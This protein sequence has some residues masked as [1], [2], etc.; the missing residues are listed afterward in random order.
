MSQ[1]R[2]SRQLRLF[3][4][5][6]KRIALAISFV[7]SIV[8]CIPA[9]AQMQLVPGIS[10]YAGNGTAG[11]SGDGGAATSAQLNQTQGVAT[12]S[13][14]NLYIAD[15]QNNRVRKVDAATGVMTT[16]AGTGTA[17]YS[18][19]GAAAT[20][21]MLKGPTGV[22]VDS[23]GNVYIADQA[24]N[25][26]RR[27]DA[28]TG[29]ITTIAGNGTT[30][31]SGDGGP[32]T[33]AAMFSPTDLI[34][35]SA[36]DLYIS[37][38]GNHRIRKVAAGTGVIT[39][40]AGNGTPGYSGDGGAATS[41][42]LYYP[43]GMVVDSAGNLYIADTFN[44]RVRKVAAGTGVITTYAGTGTAGFAGD[45][46]AAASA[47]FN[48]P[49]R[50]TLDKAGNMFIADQGNNRVREIFLGTGIITTVAGDGTAGF[51][52]DGGPGTAAAFHTPLG[53]AID[54]A[55]SLYTSDS[56]NNRIR[57]LAITANNFPSTKIG[58]TSVVQEILLQTTAAETITSITIPQ[59]Q[60]GKQ[61][62]SIGTIT[63]CTIGA[64]N[65]A[66]TVCTIPVTFTP[67]YPGQRWV[68]LQ[69][70]TSTGNINFGLTG[71]GQGPLAAL[72]P[73]IITTVVGNGTAGYA[74]DSGP[75]TTAELNSPVGVAFDSA[76]N[77]YIGDNS[78]SRVR[79]VNAAT[80]IITTVVGNGT[81]GYSG[82]G[83]PA[84]SAELN[85]PEVVALDS[86]GNLYIAEYYNN[87]I[88]K[89]AAATGIIT[90]V[91]GNGTQNYSGDGG[92]ATSA[93][94]W[95]PTGVAVDSA[96]NLY[97]ADFGNHRIR[98]VAATGIITTV[99]GNGTLGYSGD[100]GPATSAELADPTHV[101]LDSVG[102]L[103]IADPGNNR[104][105]KVTVAT[106]IITTIAGNGTAGYSGDGGPATSAAL[107]NPEYLTLD[108]AD[109][110]YIGDYLNN[111]VRKLNAA[112]GIIT[113]IAGNGT[114]AYA[115]DAGAATSA[116]LHY[117]SAIAFDNVGN[118]YVSDLGNNRTRKLDL[119]QSV[120][121]Y[122]TPT[123][124]GTSD[125]TDNPQTA[126]V[127]NIG[128][129]DLTIPPPSSG[130]NPNVGSSFGFDSAST[131]PEL[132]A[133]SNPQTL[134]AGANCTI[135]IEFDPVQAGALTGSAVLTDT[136]LNAAAVTQTIHLIATGVAAN[137]TTTLASSVNPSAYQQSVT[138]TATVVPT[139]GAALPTGT[140][141][142][143]V[144]GAAAGGPVPLNGSGVATLTSTT[145]AVGTHSI[146]A[147]Y[148]PDSTSFTASSATALS[149]V[150][151]KATLGQNGLANITLTSSPNPSNV[152]QSVTFTAT[153]PAGA[154]GTVTFKDGATTLGTGTIAGTTATFTTT[155]L[156]VGTHPVTAVY[157][158]DT[159]YN[160]ATSAITN[161]VVNNGGATNTNFL[162]AIPVATTSAPQNITFNIPAT[163]TITSI[164]IPQSQGG[165]QEYAIQSITGC[166]VGASNPAG[167]VCT[168]SITF[169][170]AYPGQRW[171]PLQVV[172]SGGNFN[173][174]LTGV[175]LGPLVALT[176]G[177]ITTVAG[178]GTAGYTGDGG[179]AT[180][181]EINAVFRQAI[182]S[183]GNIYIAE[184]GN[185]RIRKVAAGTG[186]I[187]TV[188]GDGTA[189]FSGD[190]GQATSA[191]LNGPQGVSVDSAG[192][193]YIADFNN[194]RIR[195]VNAATGV[196]T[197]V[198]GNGSGVYSGDGGPATSAGLVAPGEV[199]ADS[200]GNLYITDYNGCRIRKVAAGTGII[201]TVAGNGTPGY[202][203]DGGAATSAELQYPGGVAID[204]AGN[205]YITDQR[206]D[207]IR[208][209]SATTGIITTVAGD[210]TQG[211]SG[212]GGPATS[213]KLYY[214]G[215]ID[216]DS[217]NN[218]YF[219]DQFN[220][221]IRKV[222]AGTGVISTLAGTGPSA[223]S[224]DSGPA[225]S[226]QLGGPL[227]ISLDGAGNLYIADYGNNRIRKVDVSQSALKYPTST[228]V[229]TSDTTDDPQ[230]AIV[231]NIGNASLTVPPPSS[232][233]NPN[234]TADFQIGSSSTCPQLTGSSSSSS[235]AV[236]ANCTYA[237]NFVP[238]KQGPISGSAILTD[239]S[240]N[241][242]G[243]TQTI[244]LTGFGLA[245]TTTTSVTSSLNPSVYQQSITFTATIAPTTGTALPTGTVQFSVDGTAVGGPATLNNGTA[246]YATSTLA[247]GTHTIAAVY[248]PGSTSF[249]TSN[250]TTSQVVNP[251][252][253]TTSVASSLNPSA[254]MQSVTFTATVAP[255]A[256]T[257]LPTGTV[258]FSVDGT[259]VG[260]PVTLSGGTATFAISTLAVGLHTVT[261]VYT[262]DTGNITGSSG[263]I[264]QRVGALATSTTTLSVAPTT[265]MYGDTATLTAVVSPT[266]ATG[267]VSFYEGSTL[268]GSASLDSTG[269]AVLPN[270]TLNAGV[271]TITATYNSDPGVPAS[272]SNAV[273]LTVTQR[274]APGG[275]PAI[276]V[277]V[278][279]AS[280]STIQANP[281]FTY[282]AAGQ[283]VNGDTYATAIS[284][285]PSYSTAAGTT[286]G[287][288]SITVTGLTS[289][290]Y[291]IAFLPGTLT[292]TA[293]STT[294]TL[295][296]SPSSTQYGDPVTLTATVTSGATG[297]VSFYAGSVLLGTG[298]VSNG[299]ATLTTTTLVAGTHTITA[300]Y[301][302]DATYASSQSGPA[303]VTVAK[304]TAPGGGAALTITVQ[305]ASRQYNTADPQFSYVV[306]GTLVNGDTYATAVTGTPVYSS[307]DTSTSPAGSTFPISVSGL[308]SANYTTAF[309]NG[310][311][312][313]VT[314]PTTTALAT[315]TTS[316]QYGDPVTL[317]AT[318][319]PSG[320]TGT[321]LFMQ[322]AK[323]LGSGTVSGGVATL[324]TSTLPA[325]S[326]TITS[327]YQGDTDYGAS[328]SGPV[329]FTVT[330][331]T[332]P[333]G[334][335]ALTVTVANASRSYGQGNPAFS[336]S[337][338]GTL[339]NGDSYATAVTGVPVYST[340]AIATSPAGTYPISVTGLNSNNYLIAFVNG[341]LT[342]TKATLGQNGL[343]NFILTSSPNPSNYGQSVTFTATVPSGVTGTVQFMDGS[344]VL[345]TAA[346]SG[347]TA[348][349]T[350]SALTPGTHPVTAVYSG[351]ANYNP[352]TSAVDSQ[353][354]NQESTTTTIA[355][356]LNP[357]PFMQS[358]TFTAT[359]APTSGTDQPTGTVQFSVDGTNTGSPIT[360]SGGT[361]SFT[362]STLAVG[363][364][365]V[366][367]TYTPDTGD[368]TGSNG[369]IGQ[370]VGAVASSTTTL[371]VAPATMMYGDTATLTA[372][373]APAFATGTVSF[374]EGTTLLGTASLDNT[375]TAVLPI[376][377]LNAGVHTIVAKYNGDPGVPAN[378]SNT[379][380]LTVTQ[381]TAPGGGPAITLTVN[382][383]SRTTTQSNP[384]FTYSA[385]GQLVNGDTYATAISG[386][387]SYSTA[388]G[389]TA[390]T[391]SIT[392]SGLTSAN[393][394]I[395]FVSGT[396]TVTT[397]P[398]TTTLV[399]SPSST[400]Y[401]DP[402]TLTATVTF[403]ATGTVS[404][405]DGSV[406][407]GTGQVT[408]GIATLTTTTLAA[409][410]HTITAVYNGDATYASSQSGPATV[411]VAKKQGAGGGA[412]LTITVQNASRQYNTADPQFAYVVT[413]TLVNNDTYATAVTGTPVYLSTDTATSAAGSTFPISV[414]GLSSANYQIAFVNGTLTIVSAPTTTTLT[415]SSASAQYGDPVTL[416]ATVAPSG[417]TGTVLFMN[418]S[419]VLG[420]GTVTNGVAALTISSLP[421][422]SYTITATY[423]GDTNYGASTSGPV[424]LAIN[425]K[426]GPGGAAALTVTVTNASRGYGQGNP[427]FTYTVTGALVN[428]DTYATAVAGV[429]VYSTTAI[430]PSP[431][432][433]YPI[434]VAGLNSQNYLITVINGTL[435]VTKD[436]PGQNGVANILLTS[437]LN[438]SPYGN[439]V[440][441]T[442]SV[443]APATGTV[444]FFD[445]T[446]L[447]GTGT[448]ANGV[449]TLAT[450][451]LVVGTHPVTAV[452]SGDAD[453]N[454]ATSA[455]YN[456]VVTVQV[457]VLD[458]TLT[459]TSTGTQTVIPG[460]AAPYT[461]Q[462]APTNV[463]Y[464]GTVTFS[465]TGLPAGATITFSP[466]TVAAN[467]GTT[468]VNVSVQTTPQVA[469]DATG[470]LGKNALSV[471]L[472]LLL[473]P[474]MGSRRLRR[475]GRAAGRYVFLAVVLLGG[476]V[477]TTGLTG[478]GITDVKGN[479]FFG[480]APQ[481]YHITI[482]A[483]SGTIQH[484]VNVTLNVE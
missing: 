389:T 360:L 322:G 380:Q 6:S 270:S 368:F 327:S 186:I 293:A 301:N 123:T 446:T 210:G 346:L 268:L 194:F 163:G 167:T 377:T 453:Y 264:G 479:G 401:G 146:T 482:T 353:V 61:E 247:V 127:S 121:T 140:V 180:S 362:I 397:S 286:P 311:L 18:G 100:G 425:Q 202:A 206:N 300:V 190:G 287:T 62:Y 449:A 196:I 336:Y 159:N 408:N 147:V 177:I 151:S 95:S 185:N 19:D 320:A 443:P 259:S 357:S 319:S 50:L 189:G 343:A 277:T 339:V 281:P 421:A 74:G 294:T 451:A 267:T 12:D 227:G 91:A 288:Y 48:T 156:A 335:A 174:G 55:G 138:F 32:A 66:G 269:T 271:H 370:R 273:Q 94:L 272:T 238:T 381:R 212:D 379:V 263:S 228:I 329:T 231:S 317:T 478:C 1:K 58:A 204:S 465:A 248:T 208:K 440:T 68:P 65:P 331:R 385:A 207:R 38:D 398:S 274:T 308:S 120:L 42:E 71:I 215:T 367:A 82:D 410:T 295:V 262:P 416:T 36:G 283:L 430:P 26:V 49:A 34:F 255:T 278:N 175:G 310:T 463:T 129:T 64:S 52:G 437:S 110:L 198:A 83:G 447:L 201:T 413:G 448:V 152:G 462:V 348:S 470:K 233:N 441:F 309:V 483:T 242:V 15:W 467:G 361:A 30:G 184:Y 141:Q 148:T 257:A 461:V 323:V 450:S 230:T 98:K 213:A 282:S 75:A 391:Y 39:T 78:N 72:T 135:A 122:P 97:I 5:T 354:V 57:K 477:A 251:A 10:T 11:Y 181:A 89:V 422:G 291:S 16:V 108:S 481:T 403:G 105:R 460:N 113:T 4:R 170:P 84:T 424:S 81:A 216:I 96:N 390:G 128:N 183:A 45:G 8:T 205:L 337:V 235:L 70:V 374:Y 352:A 318:V 59:S 341:T 99:A 409:G 289:A 484:S 358:V 411:T 432:G 236:G 399:A 116:E 455:A 359:V 252:A 330:P 375:A 31:F 355:S 457:A 46:G 130:N 17:G 296:A 466:A 22:L 474:F 222:D 342:V 280:R 312:T 23:A 9:S 345:G 161:Q 134:A 433:G 240:L 125:S 60:G 284:G 305:S 101:V 29:V 313:I 76:G 306:T 304:L 192:N 218:L 436:T 452:Y 378:T 203:G 102:N 426:T 88:R 93:A 168:I 303:T 2:S 51:S 314:A 414:S 220:N 307:T 241:A 472:G 132:L 350:T 254:F 394:T 372:V 3:T 347:T 431:A 118:L 165:K 475:D 376:N 344:T 149:Q 338:T 13:A 107:H 173:V 47:E 328:T 325:G 162:P 454:S 244:G 143:S 258:Q 117:P 332:A 290:N 237:V 164:S 219:S 400:Q 142:F 155:T 456:Q 386:T 407:L 20:G 77:L 315:S 14:G 435:T 137:T 260:S 250:G 115:G 87:R 356:S 405:Y 419:T 468:A 256:G 133:S 24:N 321:V 158:G 406:L 79:K 349:L 131:C 90:T 232:G 106:G 182:D 54:N 160:T 150:V 292:V 178:D 166:T 225:T 371:T 393:Y 214:P 471:A 27:V 191:E 373:V 279:D 145:L 112:T 37:D 420:T 136:S 56:S 200:E 412:A 35:D 383:A 369:S 299:I 439:S 21:A 171:V 423:E 63:G 444:Q 434:S 469:A 176:P 223:Y 221:R 316:A 187:T 193:L 33:N 382:D 92:A 211:Y 229:G 402:V 351:D 480:Q 217:A 179:P 333:G 298:A 188:A 43:A 197:T 40:V 363:I 366:A 275:G 395:A 239:N 445:G 111:R 324:T 157:G 104:V 199:K 428:G 276:T 265:V 80:G 442:A 459:L 365:T 109:N 340:T 458:F 387:A 364:H 253:T 124:V 429:P 44:N 234:I 53:I 438:P 41:A 417:A 464:P 326:Y 334:G 384:P 473:L 7:V 302:G 388:A 86:A 476:I 153:V 249:T 126:I 69:V 103:I 28:G 246:T 245:A 144:D 209:V 114:G 427:A 415:T 119:S 67:A 25:R 266:F 172:S 418:G 297:T 169:T 285:T 85:G 404:F 396:L 73:G 243:S 224:G 154:T 226:A 139:T 392:V 195:K 261:A